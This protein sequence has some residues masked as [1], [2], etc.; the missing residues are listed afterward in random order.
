M[1]RPPA[2]RGGSRPACEGKA[3][4]RSLLTAVREFP[5]LFPGHAQLGGLRWGGD[6]APRP[7]EGSSLALGEAP[8]HA[9]IGETVR[10]EENTRTARGAQRRAR[11]YAGAG[12]R[13]PALPA[14]NPTG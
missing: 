14:L 10:T 9:N 1:P 6:H 13:I 4:V 2:D 12:C 11:R 3:R 8:P 7:A 5:C